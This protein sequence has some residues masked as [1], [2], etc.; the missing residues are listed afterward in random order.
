MIFWQNALSHRAFEALLKRKAAWA[1]DAENKL[2]L[3]HEDIMI[4]SMA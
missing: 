4:G 1:E 2:Q 3:M